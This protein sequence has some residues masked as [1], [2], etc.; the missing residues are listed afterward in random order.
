MSL[1]CAQSC[2]TLGDLMDLQST[3]TS[4]SMG[5]S[6]QEHWSGL[7]FPPQGD[8]PH[9]EIE[10]EFCLSPALQA[11]SLPLSSQGSPNAITNY[12]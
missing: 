1:L 10:P 9:P 3:Q 7:P 2:S 4:L 12:F 11:D 6:W 8:L 5:F